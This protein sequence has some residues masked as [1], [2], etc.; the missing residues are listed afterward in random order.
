MDLVQVEVIILVLGL[1]GEIYINFNQEY[2]MLMLLEVLVVCGQK[3]AMIKLMI[4]KYG[5]ELA[6]SVKDCG[7]LMLMQM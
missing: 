7:M 2:L 5:P 4:G 6:H 1:L 3:L